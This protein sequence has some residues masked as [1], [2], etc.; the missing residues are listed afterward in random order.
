MPAGMHAKASLGNLFLLATLSEL[1]RHRLT[2]LAFYALQR[3]INEADQD[4]ARRLSERRLRTE[5]QLPDFETSRRC[6]LLKRRGLV[7][8]PTV[9]R[10]A[11]PASRA[12]PRGVQFC[13]QLMS[14]LGRRLVSGIAPCA[15][16]QALSGSGLDHFEPRV[17]FA[18]VR[19]NPLFRQ[20]RWGLRS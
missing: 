18:T 17:R 5:S 6:P 3:S 8:C 16:K 7:T 13:H 15:R 14:E 11:D 9:R 4:S 1:C 12:H 20:G 10:Q 2:Y 19:G